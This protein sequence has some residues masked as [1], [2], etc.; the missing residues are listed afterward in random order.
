M[1]ACGLC[2]MGRSGTATSALRCVKW[3][4]R[5]LLPLGRCAMIADAE[6]LYI[7]ETYGELPAALPSVNYARY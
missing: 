2:V 5:G 1:P 7:C 6:S 4:S 3:R